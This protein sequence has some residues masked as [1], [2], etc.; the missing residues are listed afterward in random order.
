MRFFLVGNVLCFS[1]SFHETGLSLAPAWWI[2]SWAT[3]KRSHKQSWSQLV[4][5][6]RERDRERERERESQCSCVYRSDTCACCV[7][8]ER[9]R[10]GEPRQIDLNLGRHRSANYHGLTSQDLNHNPQMSAWVPR[11]GPAAVSRSVAVQAAPQRAVGSRSQFLSQS[12]RSEPNKRTGWKL[13]PVPN[14]RRIVFCSSWPLRSFPTPPHIR[15]SHL[16]FRDP[17]TPVRGEK[18]LPVSCY[19]SCPLITLK[20]SSCFNLLFSLPIN[21]FVFQSISNQHSGDF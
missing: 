2:F 8:E 12:L 10:R 14:K 5:K 21:L 13:T 3:K 16:L 18:A 11:C 20:P 17:P 4:P 7:Q 19:M 1:A 6:E 15:T 9:L